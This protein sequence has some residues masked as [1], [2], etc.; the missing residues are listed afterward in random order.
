M[1]RLRLPGGR[2]A[3]P[4]LVQLVELATDYGN[5][6]VQLTSRA[7]LQLRG[8]PIPLP[9]AFVA[10][11]TAT[12]LLPSTTQ[13]RV[14][15]IVASPLT[16]LHGGLADVSGLTRALD[17]GLTDAP[18]LAGLPGRFLFVLDDGRGDVIELRFD[19]GYQATGPDGGY[20][21]A[22]SS[23][24]GIAVETAEVVPT[25]LRLT[26]A[27]A[28]ARTTTGAWHVSEL[29][30]LPAWAD[31]MGLQAVP[32]TRGSVGVPLGRLGDVASVSVPLARLTHTQAATVAEVAAREVVITPWRGLVIPGAADQLDRLRATGLVTDEHDAWA[33]LSA[34]VGAPACAKSRSD[35]TAIAEALIGT[36]RPLPRTHLAGCERRCG[37]PAEEHYELV[38]PTVAQALAVVAGSQ[39]AVGPRQ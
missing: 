5:G 17:T 35:T 26:H 30:D 33:Q 28:E 39:P 12:G 29:P 9:N 36:G 19:L 31:R 23:K 2:I 16:G 11:V 14:R 27:F 4:T 15:N 24:H 32:T 13:E 20:V 3:A 34:C 8:L 1:V 21:L 6:I 22:G 38:A 37:A 18:A 10:G 25:L 7:G